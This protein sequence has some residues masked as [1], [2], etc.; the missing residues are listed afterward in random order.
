MILYFYTDGNHSGH[1]RLC[2][3]KNVRSSENEPHW[4]LLEP[5]ENHLQDDIRELK[6]YQKVPTNSPMQSLTQR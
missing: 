4:L 6:H 2:L 1:K 3:M 5:Q